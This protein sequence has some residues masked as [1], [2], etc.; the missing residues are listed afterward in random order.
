MQR[1]PQLQGDRHGVAA[2]RQA[3]GGAGQQQAE[4]LLPDTLVLRSEK[5]L[6]AG[7]PWCREQDAV[8][9]RALLGEAHVRFADRLQ[10]RARVFALRL[11]RRAHV[12]AEVFE[13]LV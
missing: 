13:G 11:Q 6:P 10:P 9:A 12:V 1:G 2:L 4:D 7:A 8:V 3:V 5:L